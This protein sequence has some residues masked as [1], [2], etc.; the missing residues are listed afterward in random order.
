MLGRDGPGSEGNLASNFENPEQSGPDVNPEL[1]KPEQAKKD[2]AGAE[3]N[4]Q[5]ETAAASPELV[6]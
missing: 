4:G 3:S 6:T 2:V 1:S 5:P